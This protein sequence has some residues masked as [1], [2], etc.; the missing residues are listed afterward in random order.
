MQGLCASGGSV[1]AGRCG[2]RA[3]T[4]IRQRYDFR[5]T[6]SRGPLPEALTFRYADYEMSWAREFGRFGG[7]MIRLLIADDH[8]IFRQGLTRLLADHDDLVVTA[9]A[10]NYAEV[11][12]A[13]RA[14][15]IDVAI[16]DLSM[17]GR[18]GVELIGHAKSLQPVMRILVMT[19]HDEEP[20][21]TQALR[22][23]ADGYM[24]KENAAE[25]LNLVIHRLF[26]GGRYVCSSVAERLALGI[27]LRDNSENRHERL[28]DRE[29][30]I[31]ELLV[32]GKRNWEIAQELSLSEKTVSTHK[33]NI[34]RKMN[35]T[36]RTELVR[37]AI[38]NQLV[39]V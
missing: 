17:P 24:T 2:G 11:I 36:N 8:Q 12:D 1:R 19:M 37:Y 7:H 4:L 28:S 15:P 27:A 6:N 5:A 38:R 26:S 34:L 20:Y 31:F 18:G 22:A 30:K 25:E 23:G 32:V 39:A 13:L 9:Q 3:T 16:L 14:G 33:V 10:A 35:V 29:Y 21:V